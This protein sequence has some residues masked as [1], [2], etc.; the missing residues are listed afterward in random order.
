MVDFPSNPV[1]G[2]TYSINSQTWLYDGAGWVRTTLNTVIPTQ[3]GNAGRYLTTNGSVVTWADSSSV[4]VVSATQPSLTAAGTLW[5]DPEYGVLSVYAS[6]VWTDVG[7]AAASTVLVADN[8]PVSAIQGNLWFNTT[9]LNT[10]VYYTD[11]DSSQWIAVGIEDPT[12][13][14][15][16]LPSQSGNSGRYL[17]TNGTT[18]SWSTFTGY[19]GSAGYLGS[20]GYTGSVSTVAGYTGSRG[21]DGVIGYNGSTGYTGSVSTVAGYTG[22]RGVDG[23][24]GYNGSTGYT[25][26][27]STAVGYSGSIGYTGSAGA[28]ATLPTQTGNSGKYLTTDGTST[29]WATIATSTTIFDG[30]APDTVYTTGPVFDAGGV[31]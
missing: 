26:S 14:A 29:S 22:S 1:A 30:G 24:I 9:D 11:G 19:A 8:P 4:T 6:G 23:V 2:N 3:T 5:Y 7:G 13:A 28:S 16:V 25:G 12:T 31:T 18:T 15:S 21:V 27:A 20:T 17:T 10:Y